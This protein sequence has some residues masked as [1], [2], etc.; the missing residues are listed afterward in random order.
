MQQSFQVDSSLSMCVMQS[1][2]SV[3][4][5]CPRCICWQCWSVAKGRSFGCSYQFCRMFV[6]ICV[7]VV[8]CCKVQTTKGGWMD[9]WAGANRCQPSYWTRRDVAP[10]SWP[11]AHD[12]MPLPDAA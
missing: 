3:F 6:K 1:P 12:S 5:L 2:R 10:L 4:L 7:T 11:N 8:P 9:L